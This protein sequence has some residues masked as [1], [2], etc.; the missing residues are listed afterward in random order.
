MSYLNLEAMTT[1]AIIVYSL[2]TSPTPTHVFHI[3]SL[4]LSLCFL[5]PGKARVLINPNLWL[6]KAQFGW[7]SFPKVLPYFFLW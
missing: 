1:L 4:G 2:L 3:P 6:S 5:C 7:N